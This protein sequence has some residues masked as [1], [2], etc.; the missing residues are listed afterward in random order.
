[1]RG[2]AVLSSGIQEFSAVSMIL[3]SVLSTCSDHNSDFCESDVSF[4]S[5]PFGSSSLISTKN[6]FHLSDEDVILMSIKSE[7]MYSLS[8]SFLQPLIII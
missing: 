7:N 4:F 3:P 8:C 6:S 5:N 1:M 2:T